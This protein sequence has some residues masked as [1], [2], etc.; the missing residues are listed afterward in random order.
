[1]KLEELVCT[2]EQA[3]KLKALGIEQNGTS[4][5]VYNEFYSTEPNIGKVAHIEI[6]VRC[7][8]GLCVV[9]G[10]GEVFTSSPGQTFAAFTS[11]ELKK[12]LGWDAV[13]IPEQLKDD[14]AFCNWFDAAYSKFDTASKLLAE[15]LIFLVKD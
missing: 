4:Y 8:K 2:P 9:D 6:G 1:M 12:A 11:D 10:D 3:K 13:N 14:T 5:F 15:T 7:A